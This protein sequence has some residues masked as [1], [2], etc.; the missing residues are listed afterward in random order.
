[1]LSL[2]VNSSILITRL[3]DKRVLNIKLNKENLLGHGSFGQAF[4]VMNPYQDGLMVCKVIDLEGKNKNF[5]LSPHHLLRLAYREIAYL[6]KLDYLIGYFYDSQNHKMYILMKYIKGRSEWS[7]NKVKNPEVDFLSFCALRACHR[8]GIAHNDPHQGNFLIDQ[9]MHSSI[10]VDFG[11]AKDHNF[12][13]EIRDYYKF[14]KKRGDGTAFLRLEQDLTYHHLLRFYCQ[15]LQ[16]YI[17][18]N[19]LKT[20]KKLFFYG[21][22]M[23]SACCGVSVLG[24]ASLIAQALIKIMLVQALSD[25]IAMLE[26]I[27]EIRAWNRV[28]SEKARH[29]YQGI[30]GLLIVLQGFLFTLNLANFSFTAANCW[31]N[32]VSMTA[33]TELAY[34]AIQLKPLIQSLHYWQEFCEKYVFSRE[35]I[36][37]DYDTKIQKQV[38]YLPKFN[39]QQSSLVKSTSDG[40]LRSLYLSNRI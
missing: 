31:Q 28:H 37:Q 33:P 8:Q 20:A 29:Y 40:E 22:V 35:K 18:N 7:I 2:P 17:Q 3:Q 6:Q 19:K 26:D 36:A 34:L 23:L 16:I 12:F 24:A 4:H 27:Y 14:L 5:D 13:R 38:V 1:M 39:A 21:A 32:W 10:A 15:E 9:K 25:F 11:L 30:S